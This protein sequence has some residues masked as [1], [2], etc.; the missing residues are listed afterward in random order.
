M[1]NYYGLDTVYSYNNMV[2]FDTLATTSTN[3]GIYMYHYYSSTAYIHDNTVRNIYKTDGST[4]SYYGIY[5]SN[6]AYQGT[7]NYYNNSV[8]DIG[9]GASTAAIYGQYLAATSVNKNIYGNSVYNMQASLT[10]NVY[11][12]YQSGGTN[13][14][15]YKNRIYGLTTESGYGYGLYILT[16][17]AQAQLSVPQLYMHQHPPHLT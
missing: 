9:V 10:G 14:E 6:A 11:G 7:C 16:L 5:L 2:E 1:Y 8:H 4:G 13:V 3:Y 15:F 17:Q 12:M